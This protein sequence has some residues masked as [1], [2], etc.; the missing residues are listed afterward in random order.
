QVVTTAVMTGGT[1][2]SNGRI[3]FG[4]S[5]GNVT[6]APAYVKLTISG[7]VMAA[8]NISSSS[9]NGRG[10]L[11]F[12]AGDITLSGGILRGTDISSRDGMNIG[13]T[14]PNAGVKMNGGVIQITSNQQLGSV[15]AVP[16]GVSPTNVVGQ[17]LQQGQWRILDGSLGLNGG[18][19]NVP[20]SGRGYSE[21]FAV[22]TSGSSYRYAVRAWMTTGTS[23]AGLVAQQSNGFATNPGDV[24]LDGKVNTADYNYM[25][26]QMGYTYTADPL[27]VTGG[28]IAYFAADATGDGVV[29]QADLDVWNDLYGQRT[30]GGIYA[31]AQPVAVNVAS[32]SQDQAAAGYTNLSF[33]TASSVTKTGGG[34]LVLN[35]ANTMTGTV[36]I[37][38]GA[39]QL[40]GTVDA[41][42]SATFKPEAGGRLTLAPYLTTSIDG[43]KP[44]A[45]G[46][47]DVGTGKVTVAA[48]GLSATDMV[49]ALVAGRGDG[50]WSGTT[51]I[52]SSD[53]A[54][55][56]GGRTV[57]WLE[58]TVV[59]TNGNAIANLGS[60]TFAFAAPGDTN[61]DWMVDILDSANFLASGKLDTGTPASWN[62]GDFTYDGFVDI[63]DA[64]AFLSTGLL[65]TGAYNPPP[66]V[67]SISAVPEPSAGAA[68]AMAGILLGWRLRRRVM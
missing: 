40:S 5:P 16:P 3:L 41:A 34:T 33:T 30:Q 6:N 46:L 17:S 7:G 36:A 42:P 25:Q 65:D 51:G 15:Y 56:G 54:A 45:G 29:N 39:V 23:D 32:G 66:A 9:N 59:D 28:L 50:T 64:A 49:T 13:G 52:T 58:N 62:Q 8:T 43:L 21:L 68:V 61:L 27:D 11:Q 38:G 60:V 67:P 10:T 47:T 14:V 4:A 31:W 22:G 26:S 44:L 12:N 35:G 1:F 63:L 19:P 57:G 53:A 24:N 55:S 48:G 20:G 18:D 2:M 37:Q